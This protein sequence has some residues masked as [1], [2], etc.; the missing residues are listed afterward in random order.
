MRPIKK[1]TT[2]KTN[3]MTSLI[4]INRLIKTTTIKQAQ[5]KLGRKVLLYHFALDKSKFAVAQTLGVNPFFVDGYIKAAQNYN[6][7]KLKVIFSYLKEYDLKTKGVDNA[8]VNNGELMKEL[9]FKIL[10]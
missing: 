10:H 8:G 2:M 6:T 4:L 9:I 3:L 5:I 7:S 1:M